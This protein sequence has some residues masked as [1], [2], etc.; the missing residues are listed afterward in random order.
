M[1]Q[2]ANWGH[3]LLACSEL[4]FGV[5]CYP[6]HLLALQLLQYR[7]A[8]NYG[9][10][11]HSKSIPPSYGMRH[12]CKCVGC[13]MRVEVV[14]PN[15]NPNLF[16]QRLEVL[17]I[18]AHHGVQLGLRYSTDKI[19]PY[20]GRLNILAVLVL[21]DGFFILDKTFNNG[22]RQLDPNL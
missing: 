2:I 3:K 21:V 9:N 22:N 18:E 12:L 1:I 5:C 6:D 13:K 11:N 20:L 10:W 7:H 17:V 4:T 16:Q 8:W 15:L 19:T 14:I